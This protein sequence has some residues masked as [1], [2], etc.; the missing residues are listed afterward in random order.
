MK[1]FLACL[2]L[3]AALSVAGLLADPILD[4]ANAL[5]KAGDAAAAE[6]LLT[7][8]LGK[9]G[10]DGAYLAAM[11]LQRYYGI[12]RKRP[13]HGETPPE[14]FLGEDA[15]F[16]IDC[17]E[18]AI[19]LDGAVTEDAYTA[20]ADLHVERG[21]TTKAARVLRKGFEHHGASKDFADGYRWRM[22]KIAQGWTFP[23]FLILS[24]LVTL[25]VLTKAL[26][27]MRRRAL[28]DGTLRPGKGGREIVLE[29]ELSEAAWGAGLLLCGW[30]IALVLAPEALASLLYTADVMDAIVQLVLLFAWLM[31]FGCTFLFFGKSALVVGDDGMISLVSRNLLSET[32]QWTLPKDELADV[33]LSETSALVTVGLVPRTIPCSRIE[34]VDRQGK[35][36]P[37]LTTSDAAEAETLVAALG[38]A[39]R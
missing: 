2:V 21:E 35:R 36:H 26:A 5:Y 22:T 34:L 17:L 10:D 27:A 30:V 4:R 32:V 3:A 13:V 39:L 23:F 6:A 16:A 15:R 1:P 8:S 20:L 12:S 25:V 33:V 37:V 28:S 31:F 19:A 18:R 9:G 7:A 24:A 11:G 29:S 14:L 38:E